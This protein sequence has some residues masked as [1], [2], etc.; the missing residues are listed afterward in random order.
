MSSLVGVLAIGLM[1]VVL[2]IAVFSLIVT[3]TIPIGRY[4]TKRAERRTARDP[5]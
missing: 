3:A 1:V 4:L 5:A 2:A